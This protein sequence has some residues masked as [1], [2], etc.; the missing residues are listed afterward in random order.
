MNLESHEPKTKVFSIDIETYTLGPVADKYTDEKDYKLGNVKDPDKI[1][2]ALK[3]KREDA[4]R[5]HA[6]HW[7]T[8]KVISVAL[9]DVLGDEAELCLSSHDEKELLTELAGRLN[10]PCK[11]VGKSSDMFDYGFLVGRYMANNLEVPGVLKRREKLF[12]I[13]KFFSWSA[14]SSQRGSLQDYAFGL[15]MEGKTMKGSD[16]AELYSQIIV[17]EMETGITSP[18]WQDLIEYNLQDARIVADLTRRY[19]GK[20][21]VL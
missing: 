19:I 9:V 8:G 14:Q 12:D 17:D 2:A 1:K 20:E 5:T 11:L 6:L 21:G 16:V 7:F 10:R 13:D 3:K 4:R 15:D 18:L